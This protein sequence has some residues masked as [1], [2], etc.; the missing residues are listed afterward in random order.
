[1][2]DDHNRVAI[3]R[4]L[5]NHFHQ[6]TDIFKMKTCCWLIENIKGGPGCDLGQLF[7]QLD[8]LGLTSGKSCRL[9]AYFDIAKAHTVKCHQ[10]VAD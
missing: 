5:L 7:G 1:M 10:L 9:L 8:P 4:K 3:I 6:P 2:L